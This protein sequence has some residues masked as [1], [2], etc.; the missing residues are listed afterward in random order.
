M[1]VKETHIFGFANGLDFCALVLLSSSNADSTTVQTEEDDGLM[2]TLI[3]KVIN[4]DDRV[5][6]LT[7]RKHEG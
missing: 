5:C 6:G 7:K 3:E 4:V 1:Y 2:Y